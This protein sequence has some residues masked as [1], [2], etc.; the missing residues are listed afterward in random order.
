MLY[1]VISQTVLLLEF[2]SNVLALKQNVDV[3]EKSTANT[4]TVS[5]Y[6]MI[7]LK[8]EILRICFRE[9]L[10]FKTH[11][12]SSDNSRQKYARSRKKRCAL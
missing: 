7:I 11:P 6:S 2:L 4:V 10:V 8:I 5:V 3:A 1:D 9:I 12:K